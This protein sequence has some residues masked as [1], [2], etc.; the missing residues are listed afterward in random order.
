ML[1]EFAGGAVVYK[2]ENGK[3]LF[4]LVFSKR[5]SEWGFPKGHIE[6]NETEIAAAKREI[7][8]E[9]GISAIKFTDGF[10]IEDVYQIKGNSVEKHSVYFLAKALDEPANYDETEISSVGW[11]DKSAAKSKL[12]F[13]KQK[14][15]LEAADKAVSEIES[16]F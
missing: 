7:F 13:E 14:E 1:K 3:P 16:R 11:F 4:L 9:T 5:N 12:S 15:I 2:I 10:R 6:N 8:E